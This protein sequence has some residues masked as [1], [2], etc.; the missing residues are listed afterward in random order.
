MR[1]GLLTLHL[2]IPGCASLKEKRSQIKPLVA[3]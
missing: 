1:I 2:R 3:R